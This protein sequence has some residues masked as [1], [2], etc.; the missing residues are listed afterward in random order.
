MQFTP[1]S[2]PSFCKRKRR[3]RYTSSFRK[4]P[5][6]INSILV[7]Q[8]EQDIIHIYNEMNIF[9]LQKMFFNKI[10]EAMMHLL[11]TAQPISE[12]KRRSL[13]IMLDKTKCSNDWRSK[14]LSILQKEGLLM[15]R[16][17]KKRGAH[18]HF[19]QDIPNFCI[20]F[21]QYNEEQPH[22]LKLFVIENSLFDLCGGVI[23]DFYYITKKKFF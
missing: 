8:I 22:E 21:V 18:F 23:V 11:I 19:I 16:G 6:R 9:K 15:R 3:I 5:L 14:W 20:L 4:Y 2:L 7:N 12:G 13:Q 17:R 1:Q 10:D